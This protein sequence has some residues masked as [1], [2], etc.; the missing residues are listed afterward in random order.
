MSRKIA[1]VLLGLFLL[2]AG[3]TVCIRPICARVV[4]EAF[5]GRA[6]ALR[7]NDVIWDWYEDEDIDWAVE[8]QEKVTGHKELDRAA[9]KYLD[10]LAVYRRAEGNFR[11]PDIRENLDRLNQDIARE[12]EIKFR[13]ELKAAERTMFLEELYE[14]ESEVIEILSELPY[15]IR[16]FGSPAWMALGLYA[17]LTSWSL[18][19]LLLL[20]LAALILWIYWMNR[21]KGAE[22]LRH[23]AFPFLADG[24][25][26]GL[27]LPALVRTVSYTVTNRLIGRAWAIDTFAFVYAGAVLVLIGGALLLVWY[28]TERIL[29]SG[30]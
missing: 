14:A 20:I 27:L 15:F 18:R 2:L 8:L 21:G 16:N 25:I 9:A 19:F 17:I 11:E 29:G 22:C 12:L 23:M 7:A 3:I 10:A 13:T 4:H 1:A 28:W 26:L 5:L 24:V 6:V 30:R